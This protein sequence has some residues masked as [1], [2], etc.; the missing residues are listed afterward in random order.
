MRWSASGDSRA[1]GT[2]TT[3]TAFS[4]TPESRSAR[5]APSS[6][7]SPIS[8]LKRDRTMPT[9]MFSARALA[10]IRRRVMTMEEKRTRKF[11]RR[12]RDEPAWARLARPRTDGNVGIG[13]TRDLQAEP[14]HA[15]HLSRT[16]KEPHLT[17]LEIAQ[18]LCADAVVAQI[19]AS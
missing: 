18:N 6:R 7:S 5:A 17:D 1:P 16:R 4:S 14:R 3:T 9:R 2:V 12:G 11:E 19:H 8:G 10:V 13:V 15:R